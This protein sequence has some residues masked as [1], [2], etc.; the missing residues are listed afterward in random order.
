MPQNAKGCYE[1]IGYPKVLRLGEDEWTFKVSGATRMVYECAARPEAIAKVMPAQSSPY[2]RDGWTQNS[3]EANALAKVQSVPFAPRIYDH[4]EHVF[5]NRWNQTDIMDILVLTKLGPDLQTAASSVPLDKYCKAYK[6]AL[7]ATKIFAEQDVVVVD[8]HA[9][10]CSL[11]GDKLD[12]ALPCDFGG[13][14][15]A[16]TATARKSLKA[17]CGG[18]LKMVREAHG[19]DLSAA[20]PGVAARISSAELPLQS[21]IVTDLGAFFL[22]PTKSNLQP[23][24]E[25]MPTTSTGAT[26]ASEPAP[27]PVPQPA[28]VATA[29]VGHFVVLNGLEQRTEL[30]GCIGFVQRVADDRCVT[31]LQN[32]TVKSIHASHLTPIAHPSDAW[33]CRSCKANVYYKH[34]PEMGWTGRK[35]KWNCAACSKTTPAAA[36]QPTR[37]SIILAYLGLS[38]SAGAEDIKATYKQWLLTAH[39][40]KGGDT[41]TFAVKN[42][43]WKELL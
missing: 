27:E 15:S 34:F 22:L 4:F 18:F 32:N 33:L 43:F 12:L 37:R 29:V 6:A 14:T 28:P 26:H 2:W 9:Y 40:D 21:N 16:S 17:L 11:Y 31:K 20:W 42:A 5:V 36:P 39:P 23:S 3:T 8:P 19:I 25:P 13:A 1:K 10:N 35:G 24:P 38:P 7:W 30:N 41:Q